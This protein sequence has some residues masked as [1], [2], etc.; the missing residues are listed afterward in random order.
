VAGYFVRRMRL[1]GGWIAIIAAVAVSV[2]QLLARARISS[3]GL[4]INIAIVVLI[5]LNWRYLRGASH[6]GA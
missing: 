2:L 6:V 4:L 1:V 5:A 3:I